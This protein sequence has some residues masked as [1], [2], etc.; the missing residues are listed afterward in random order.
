MSSRP[1][2]ADFK[3]ILPLLSRHTKTAFS[4]PLSPLGF[5]QQSSLS[6]FVSSSVLSGEMLWN[7]SGD[8]SQAE[9]QAAFSDVL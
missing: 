4:P 2:E 9:C 6:S 1:L 5:S 3:S 7:V 8:L